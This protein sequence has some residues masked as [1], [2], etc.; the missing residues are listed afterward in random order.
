L[1]GVGEHPRAGERR[2]KACVDRR[3]GFVLSGG[4][5]LQSAWDETL[6]GASFDDMQRRHYTTPGFQDIDQRN[7]QVRAFVAWNDVK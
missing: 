2:T 4:A 3:E 5:F 6:T 1:F 7:P